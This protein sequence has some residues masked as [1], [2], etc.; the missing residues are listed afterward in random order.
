MKTWLIVTL[1][2]LVLLLTM[3]AIWAW[4][5][6]R[7]RAELELKYLA[8][9]ADLIEVAGT[10]LHV[11]DSGGVSSGRVLI[12]VHG[13]GAHLQTWDVW[14]DRL[15]DDFRVIRL[16]LPGAGLSH[17]DAKNDYSDDRSSDILLAL[18]NQ[19]DIE[20][21]S[22]IGNSIGG[23]IAWKFASDHGDRIDKLVLISPDGYASPGFEYGKSAEVPF[24]MSMM[25]YALP[26]SMLRPNL[27]IAYSDPTRLKQNVMDRYHDLMLAPGN[28]QA[29]LDRMRQTVLV[30]P[31]P[32]LAKIA[33][34]VLLLWGEDD[35]MIPIDNAQDYLEALHNATLVSLPDLGHVP[36]EEDG[37]VSLVPVIDF[38]NR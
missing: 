22:L 35:R 38:L 28:R 23:R 20:M 15:K 4:T 8:D 10:K 18:M 30:P 32:L 34:P 2:G 29:L 3:A 6:D 27:E 5:P 13:L 24:I 7:P 14:A 21:A 19:L 36:H 12:L 37:R 1:I 17:P 9:P 16:D 26:K 25:K 11:R 33:A 31:E